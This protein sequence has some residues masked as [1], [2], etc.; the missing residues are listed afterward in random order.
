[1]RTES[2]ATRHTL[3]RRQLLALA[4]PRGLVIECLEGMLWLTADGAA[5]DFVVAAGQRVRLDGHPRVVI[6]ALKDSRFLARP[7]AG[8]LPIRQLAAHCAARLVD[9]LR[10]WRHRPLAGYGAAWLR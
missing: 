4:H 1:M 3:D 9:H 6:S 8:E 2:Q 5:G 10:R 7:G